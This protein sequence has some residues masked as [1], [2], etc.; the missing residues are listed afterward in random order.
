MWM[1]NT[2][3]IASNKLQDLFCPQ[4][5]QSIVKAGDMVESW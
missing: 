1:W 2:N 5:I 4:S 3:S